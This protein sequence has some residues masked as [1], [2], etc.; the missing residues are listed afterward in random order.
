MDISLAQ[1]PLPEGRGKE[2]ELPGTK[3][4]CKLMPVEYSKKASLGW[5]DIRQPISP[6]YSDDASND[7]AQETYLEGTCSTAENW[8]PS[9]GRWQLGIKMDD[10]TILFGGEELWEAS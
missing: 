8:W 3:R 10:A 4:W 7:G 1:P 6:E 2:G 9:L 5:W